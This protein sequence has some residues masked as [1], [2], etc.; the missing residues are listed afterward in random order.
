MFNKYGEVIENANLK[1]YTTYKINSICKYLVKPNSIDN[2][3]DLVKYLKQE[4]IKYFILGNGSNVIFKNEYFDGVVIRLDLLNNYE[5][6][7]DNMILYAEC[8]VYMPVISNKLVKEGYNLFTWAGGLPGEIGG[9]ICGNA[10]AYKE[11]ISD[12]LIDVKVLR[13]NEI[14]TLKKED[15][16]F[17]Y[18]TSE[19][20]EEKNT[21]ILSARFKLEKGNTEEMLEK[22]KER[23]QRRLST[24]PLEYPS[25][26]S[27]FRNPNIKDYKEVF[28]KY[29]LPVNAEG[30]V[31]AGYLIEQA[32][33]KGKKIGGAMVSEKHANFILNVDNATSKDVIDLIN[34]VRDKVKEKFEIDLI[35]EQEIIDFDK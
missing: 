34:L 31:S 28:E 7:E 19:F 32:G 12:K 11:S 22:M 2:L 21:I 30:F 35:L 18:R 9:S 6:D 27:T 5:I 33:L 4:N 23:A 3:I 24:Q 14:K 17:G 25:A 1:D 20:K 29:D 26:G 8:G 13:D 16:R 15:I 10:E